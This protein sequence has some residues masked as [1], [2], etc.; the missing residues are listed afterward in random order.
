MKNERRLSWLP[1]LV[2]SALASPACM[3]EPESPIKSDEEVVFFPTCGHLSPDGKEWLLEVHGWIYE[4]IHESTSRRAALSALRRALGLEKGE[5]RT[6]TFVRRA[7]LFLT[8]NERG[9]RIPIRIGETT[10][11]LRS[12][13]ANGHFQDVVAIPVAE[14]ERALTAKG[15][16]KDWLPYAALVKAG[17]PRRFTGRVQLVRDSGL[18]V[19]SDI[20]DTIKITGVTDPR[21]LVQN[22]F[23]RD[24]E[25]VSGMA[26]FYREIAAHGAQFHYLSNSPWQLYAPL[27]AFFEAQ[28]FPRGTYHMRLFRLKDSSIVRF[29][30]SPEEH[31]R[32]TLEALLK[33]FPR[34]RFVLV[35][36]TGERDPEIYGD[37]GRRYAGQV[38][39]ILLRDPAGTGIVTPR[40]REALREIPAEKWSVFA[41]AS[42]LK[43]DSL[44]P[45][46]E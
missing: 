39:R 11:E 20:D 21:A 28:G 2:V 10:V 23:L 26:G 36:D 35:G 6:E 1:V 12:S 5:A 22:T 46:A 37:V 38:E 40:L 18:S 7:G 45:R 44:T 41:D 29:L 31:K 43:W 24:Y 4:P 13:R 15:A 25:A 27:S 33:Q 9:K 8:D 42:E 34:R 30:A 16:S 19:V 17:D 32:S 3:G 14:V